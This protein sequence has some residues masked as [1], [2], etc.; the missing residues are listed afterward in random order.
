MNRIQPNRRHRSLIQALGD[1]DGVKVIAEIKRASPSKGILC[2]SLN[3]ARTA[4]IYAAAGAV[5]ISVLTDE[6]FFRGGTEDLIQV[7]AATNL[8]VLR[9]E[10][11]ISEYQVIE[12]A[13]LGADVI[14]LIARILELGQLRR[15]LKLCQELNLEA[16]VEV[17]SSEDIKKVSQTDT[18]LV[19]INNRDLRTFDTQLS[20]ALELG[21]QLLPGQIPIVASGIHDVDDIRL[22][23]QAGLK[24]FLIGESLVR[25]QSPGDRLKSYLEVC[26]A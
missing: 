10:F 2:E 21:K 14:L 23:C 1:H 7:R 19:G 24:N 22:N 9:K 13:A 15:Y 8:P 4:E 5:A 6:R 17:H 12:S 11:I 25:A 18:R 20:R 16:L 3:A 26:Y